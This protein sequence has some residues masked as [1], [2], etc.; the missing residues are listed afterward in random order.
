MLCLT[1]TGWPKIVNGQVLTDMCD[2]CID[3]L[4]VLFEVTI[5]SS[6]YS[7]ERMTHSS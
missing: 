6:L 1:G 3:R 4:G 7:V 2:L 5:Y